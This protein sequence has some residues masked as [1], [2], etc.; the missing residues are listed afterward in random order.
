MGRII[1][2]TGTSEPPTLNVAN[3]AKAAVHA[4]ATGLS[5]DVGKYGVC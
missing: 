4:R 3:P 2:L 5:R 1:S